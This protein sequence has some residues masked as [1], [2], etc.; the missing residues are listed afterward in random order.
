MP[1][2]AG[3]DVAK[4]SLQLSIIDSLAPAKPLKLTSSSFPNSSDGFKLLAAALSSYGVAKVLME[5]TGGLELALHCALEADGYAVTVCNPA[6][7]RSFSRSLGKREKTDPV[8]AFILARMLLALGLAPTP[9]HHDLLAFRRLVSRRGQ[10]VEHRKLEYQYKTS[11]NSLG[12][13]AYSP[14]IDL[15]SQQIKSVEKQLEEFIEANPEFKRKDEL[16]SGV[17][18]VGRVTIY[19]LLA[20]LPELGHANERQI[21][22][23]V[24]VAPLLQESGMWKGKAKIQGGR[25][26]VRNVLYMSAL[27]GLTHNGWIASI[28]KEHSAKGGKHALVVC[29]RR[30]LIC[31]N[32]MVAKNIAWRPVD[33]P[34]KALNELPDK[35]LTKASAKAGDKASSVSPVPKEDLVQASAG[36]CV[37]FAEQCDSSPCRD[38]APS[39]RTNKT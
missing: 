12:E 36:T 29:M 2:Y 7:A 19:T 26:N 16:M 10:L 37:Q 32:R 20:W 8:D 9:A 14:L 18:G 22:K 39:K 33:K 38:K 4:H 24:G 35:A 3:V 30:L 11:P 31:L 34:K 15:L 1:H 13:D 6:Q 25:A 23:L 27:V 28:Y 5:S 21:A 17:P